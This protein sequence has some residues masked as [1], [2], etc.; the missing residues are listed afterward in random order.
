[1]QYL[2]YIFPKS[3][4]MSPYFLLLQAIINCF[5]YSQSPL[6]NQHQHGAS[7]SMIARCGP[8]SHTN[9]RGISP[10]S[11]KYSGYSTIDRLRL[12]EAMNPNPEN[13]RN[14][15]E[16]DM[17]LIAVQ[18]AVQHPLSVHK[19]TFLNGQKLTSNN[20]FASLV[21]SLFLTMHLSDQIQDPR[22]SVRNIVHTE[23][24]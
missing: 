15:A 22:R 12:S 2:V 17:L 21:N 7:V 20:L 5:H 14:S 18:Q 4:D 23:K 16:T 6:K 19:L 3:G 24:I 11:A 10:S 8:D 9:Y 13:C 1:M